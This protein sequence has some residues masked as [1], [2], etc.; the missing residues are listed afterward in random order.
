M[1]GGGRKPSL[2]KDIE[3]SI[4]AFID[5]LRQVEQKVS[6]Q[7]LVTHVRSMDSSLNNIEKRTLRR[8]IWRIL[9][10]NNIGIR[11]TTHVAQNTRLCAKVMSDWIS[12]IQNKMKI[13]GI[14]PDC[15]ANFDETPVFLHPNPRL[16]SIDAATKQFL[17]RKWEQV[18]NA[19]Q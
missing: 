18:N 19:R 8:R 5:E 11:R 9:H 12:Y 7:M 6:I 13:F 4:L 17:S 3:K 14:E 16:R 10:R 15:V 2:N 1:S